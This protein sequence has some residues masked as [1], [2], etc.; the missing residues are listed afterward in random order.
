MTP[1]PLRP[2]ARVLAIILARIGDTLLAT[3]ALR[4]LKQAVPRGELVVCA[5]PER[6]SVLEGLPF[7]DR[8]QPFSKGRA[9]L[10]GWLGGPRYA[11][12]VVWGKD[13]PLLAYARRVAEQV[14]AFGQGTADRMLWVAPPT[15]PLHAVPERLLLPQALGLTAT[16]LRL[17][18]HVRFTEQTSARQRLAGLAQQRPWIGLQLQSFPSKAYRDWPVTHFAEVVRGLL[19]AHTNAH[20]LILGDQHSAAPGA[21][22]AAQ[23]PGRVTVVAGSLSLRESAAVMSLLDLYIGVDTGPTHL[24][25]A[26]GIPMVAL[27]HCYHPGRLLAPLDHPQLAVIEHPCSDACRRETPMA[28]LPPAPVLAAALRLLAPP[29]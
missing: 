21:E 11:A 20:I 25:G 15:T 7:I 2:D 24:A 13:A 10:G 18:Y 9:R 22:L 26:L 17:A 28:Q 3:P 14:A 19:Q 16:D 5:H 1:S 23:F 29:R 8:L 12:A 6:L 4:A 27:Y